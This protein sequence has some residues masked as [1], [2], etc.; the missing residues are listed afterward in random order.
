M[1]Q[2]KDLVSLDADI[3]D[4]I[5]SSFERVKLSTS[6]LTDDKRSDIT[7]SRIAAFLLKSRAIRS[8]QFPEIISDIDDVSWHILLDLT[9]AA[10]SGHPATAHDLSAA[11]NVPRSIMDRYVEY[12]IRVGLIDKN[13]DAKD[14]KRAA[15]KLT[16]SGDE[17]TS[18]TLQKISRELANF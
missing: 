15:L 13:I 10:S 3:A 18:R 12:L 5:D 11:H 1:C 16:A 9:V 2:H 7:P 6:K 14:D 8:D 4:S 17:L